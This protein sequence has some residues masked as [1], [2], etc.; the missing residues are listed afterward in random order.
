M[1]FRQIR[2]K[3]LPEL[4]IT[5]ASIG[6]AGINST[7]VIKLNI[8]NKYI[9]F[10]NMHISIIWWPFRIYIKYVNTDGRARLTLWFD[11]YFIAC[12]CLLWFGVRLNRSGRADMCFF[13]QNFLI[14][15]HI[16]SYYAISI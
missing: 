6:T 1:F 10:K 2:I 7:E 8:E 9:L 14:I 3:P 11:S 13:Q 16:I 5:H 12:S 15:Y 4:I